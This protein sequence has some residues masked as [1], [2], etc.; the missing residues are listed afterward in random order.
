MHG[1]AVFEDLEPGRYQAVARWEGHLDGSTTVDARCEGDAE[2]GSATITL[3]TGATVRFEARDEDGEPVRDALL[4]VE[5]SDPPARA[6]F[7]GADGLQFVHEQRSDDSG[8]GLVSG[9]Y[10]GDYR[11][12]ARM[13]GR[14][15]RTRFVRIRG[16]GEQS[17][18]SLGP[19]AETSVAL[20]VLP[21]ASLEATLVCDDGKAL[22]DAV[23]AVAV[24]AFD[25]DENGAAVGDLLAESELALEDV[26]LG[27]DL[28]EDLVV[29]PLEEDVYLLALRPHGF[30]H[31][32]W[33]GSG[34]GP[35]DA[36]EVHAKI[37]ETRSA[38]IVQV[39]CAPR[40]EV[41]V[42]VAEGDREMFRR[43]LLEV[44]T[45][46]E[47]VPEGH[48][49]RVTVSVDGDRILLTG[50]PASEGALRVRLTHPHVLPDGALEL[51]VKGR[52]ER[53]RVIEKTL[54]VP[55]LGGAIELLA[56][57][58]AVRVA[59]QVPTAEPRLGKVVSERVLVPALEPGNYTVTLCRDAACSGPGDGTAL[60]VRDLPVERGRTT[61]LELRD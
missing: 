52:F 45:T 35:D 47:T 61:T 51:E 54:T 50:M 59:Q 9:L 22:P 58:P 46:F 13:E 53:G 11:L 56:R 4:V 19:G 7:G 44:V 29:G 40:V 21:A 32:T 57:A 28:R 17:D 42:S 37:G 55:A 8:R 36:I 49:H 1:S 27:G 18:V 43:D 39:P 12:S 25:F 2:G 48:S 23:S 34:G 33:A 38:G 10:A 30:R 41:L 60:V 15:A 5:A 31:W 16:A 26:T 24:K 20:E 3:E 14:H 6:V